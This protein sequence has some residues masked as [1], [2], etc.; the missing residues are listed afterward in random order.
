MVHRAVG[1]EPLNAC[2]VGDVVVAEFVVIAASLL[3]PS[4]SFFMLSKC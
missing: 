3:L 1:R 2:R 4:L